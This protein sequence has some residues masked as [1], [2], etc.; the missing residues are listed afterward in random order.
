MV[1]WHLKAFIVS[2]DWV[3]WDGGLLIV[4]PIG[5]PYVTHNVAPLIINPLINPYIET[6]YSYLF[7]PLKNTQHPTPTMAEWPSSHGSRLATFD[8]ASKLRAGQETGGGGFTRGL[9]G[10]WGWE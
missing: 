7:L 4:N 10:R 8:A 1:S 6:V 5:A 9:L 3:P 2:E